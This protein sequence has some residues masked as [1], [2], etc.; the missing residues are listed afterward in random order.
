[1]KKLIEDVKKAKYDLD[2]SYILIKEKDE[3]LNAIKKGMS[4]MGG[5][6]SNLGQSSPLKK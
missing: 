5:S 6:T 1:M 4:F 3:E 2:I